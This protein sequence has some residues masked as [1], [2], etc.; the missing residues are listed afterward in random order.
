MRDDEILDVM[1]ETITD[2]WDVTPGYATEL[3]RQLV[4]SLKK[5]GV[6]I[7]VVRPSLWR[8]VLTRLFGVEK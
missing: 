4:I 1:A 8:R 7:S 6:T 3:A 5:K 2:D